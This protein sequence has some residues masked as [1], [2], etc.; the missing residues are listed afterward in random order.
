VA[1]AAGIAAAVIAFGGA[2]GG[3]SLPDGTQTFSESDHTHVTGSVQYDRVPPAGGAHNPVPQNC[4]VYGQ[5][6]PNE[7]AVHSLE[8]GTVWITYRPDLPGS[9]VA[10]LRRLA[11]SDYVGP[12]RYVLLSPYPG[13]PAPIVAS[14]WGAQ[15][16]LQQ[17]SDQ[18]LNAFVKHY[19]R[20]S[21]G[22]EQGGPCSGGSGVPME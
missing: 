15:L 18:R 2:S 17:A 10:T 13:L 1:A 20:G 3:G 5:P 11:V 22:G 19:A 4:G 6:I 12:Q 21:Q 14:A 7:N 16:R 9:Q 8:H